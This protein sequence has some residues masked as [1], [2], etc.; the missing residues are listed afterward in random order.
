MVSIKNV[1]PRSCEL[2]RPFA[3]TCTHVFVRVD[4]TEKPLQPPYHGPYRVI[5][6]KSKL[7]IVDLYGKQDSISVD[8]LKV[9]YT[10]SESGTPTPKIPQPTSSNEPQDKPDR[11]TRSGRC[12]WWPSRYVQ[13]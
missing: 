3:S 12:V 4:A 11:C 9:A 5:D 13:T 2:C 1:Q 6:R 8:R 7:F 10:N